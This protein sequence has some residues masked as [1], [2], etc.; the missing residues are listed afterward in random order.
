M[1]F[2][3]FLGIFASLEQ[4]PEDSI[5]QSG[6]DDDKMT[7]KTQKVVKNFNE[8]LNFASI[9]K[10]RISDKLTVNKSIDSSSKKH[11]PLLSA[12][13]LIKLTNL[14]FD[15]SDSSPNRN[16]GIESVDTIDGTVV[17]ATIQPLQQQPIQLKLAVANAEAS[18]SSID[19]SSPEDSQEYFPMTTSMT[20]ELR[21]ELE[22]LDRHVFGN[23]YQQQQRQQFSSSVCDTP[24]AGD[25]SGSNTVQ[26]Q[27]YYN[28]SYTKLK[29]LPSTDCDED[30]TLEICRCPSDKELGSGVML[31]KRIRNGDSADSFKRISTSSANA[32]VFIWENP[33]HQFSPSSTIIDIHNNAT[34]GEA[35]AATNNYDEEQ[36]Q[37]NRTHGHPLN[38]T[39]PDE[40]IDLEYDESVI[41]TTVMGKKTITP[42]RLVCKNGNDCDPSVPIKRKHFAPSKRISAIFS[43]ND[44]DSD[45][46]SGGD[47]WN[48]SSPHLLPQNKADMDEQPDAQPHPKQISDSYDPNNQSQILLETGT[49]VDSSTQLTTSV[50]EASESNVA[51]TRVAGSLPAPNEFGGGNP[52]L[53]F[54]CLTLLLQHRNYVIKSNMDY[55]EMAMHFDK[56]VRKHNVTSVLNQSRRM[57]SDY[58]K[59]QNM[60]NAIGV[61]VLS[62]STNVGNSSSVSS[63]I[64]TGNNVSCNNTAALHNSGITSHGGNAVTYRKHKT[65]KGDVRT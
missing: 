52:F 26:P 46:S 11:S 51:I 7:S 53:M 43:A 33:L 59:S 16:E 18:Q 23:D 65:V 19:G 37:S 47:S 48:E 21:L 39:T 13:P 63:S 17:R 20:R 62:G 4:R 14:S 44:S 8:F 15:E 34:D 40:Q 3:K 12:K 50:E 57:Y 24:E 10:S 45:V 56:M 25:S 54:L 31:R 55:N 1:E 38:T 64:N 60:M 28:I 2:C 9:N 41:E 30:G 58:L 42:I 35:I 6:T 29:Q 27:N 32:D 5:E 49:C 22:N 36:S 61:T